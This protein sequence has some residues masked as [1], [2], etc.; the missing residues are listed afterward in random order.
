MINHTKKDFDRGNNIEEAQQKL[1]YENTDIWNPILK[2]GQFSDED[3]KGREDRQFEL[4]I[5]ADYRESQ[6]RKFTIKKTNTKL[7]A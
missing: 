3:V 6:K 4:H 7:M 2:A 5:K 1:E